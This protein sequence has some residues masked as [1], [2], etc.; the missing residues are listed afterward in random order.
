MKINELIKKSKFI[1]K[2]LLVLC[3]IVPISMFAQTTIFSEDFE[4]SANYKTSDNT[5]SG[6]NES[7]WYWNELTGLAR[8]SYGGY[9]SDV[10]LGGANGTSKCL[11]LGQSTT[12]SGGSR[13]YANVPLNS[14][15]SGYDIELKFY[16]YSNGDE[17]HTGTSSPKGTY[18]CLNFPIKNNQESKLIINNR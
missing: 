6:L 8:V 2:T 13:L 9:S 16:A 10:C 11:V 5:L 3:C 18:D 17:D 12:S 4:V 14:Y 1:K 7:A 15:T